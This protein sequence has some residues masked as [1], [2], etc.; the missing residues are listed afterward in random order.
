MR[1]RATADLPAAELRIVWNDE[2][3]PLAQWLPFL[4][5][6]PATV[7]VAAATAPWSDM[8][9]LEPQFQAMLETLRLA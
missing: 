8:A 3:E 6:D 5:A 1:R 4:A 7:V 9:T 2:A